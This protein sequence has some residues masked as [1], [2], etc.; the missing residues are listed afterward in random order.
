M[1]GDIVY[2]YDTKADNG[3]FGHVVM[4]TEDVGSSVQMTVCGHTTN[5]K[6]QPRDPKDKDAYFHIYDE[7]PIKPTDYFG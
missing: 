6:D 1:K 4:L 2:T 7:L 3:T 5:Q